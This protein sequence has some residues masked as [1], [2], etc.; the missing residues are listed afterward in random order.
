MS[1]YPGWEEN[2]FS[3]KS[4]WHVFRKDKHFFEISSY[5]TC[6][7]DI[8][9][10]NFSKEYAVTIS[11]ALPGANTPLKPRTGENIIENGM[12]IHHLSSALNHFSSD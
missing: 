6:I 12:P 1:L 10:N 8:L 7:T 2:K 4:M 3:N 5:Y 9:L 11:L